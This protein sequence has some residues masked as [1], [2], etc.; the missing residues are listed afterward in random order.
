MLF[1]LE[2]KNVKKIT[3]KTF[4]LEKDIQS[5]VE[6]NME[7]LLGLEFITTEFQVDN[8]N[9]RLDSVAYDKENNAFKIIEYKRG[10]NE[11]LIDQGYTYLNLLFSNKADF[12]LKYNE[13]KNKNLK[14]SDID[15]EQSRVVFISQQF[16]NYQTKANNFKNNPIELIRI[17]KY[18]D[19]IIELDFIEKNSTTE[20]PFNEQFNNKISSVSKQ[21][22]VYTE[23]E[24]INKTS[25]ELK[26]IYY[27][28][29]DVILSWGNIKID[30]K[31]LY[32]AFKGTT[33]IVDIVFYRS[34]LKMSLN[35]KYGELDDLKGLAEDVRNIGKWGNG[36]YRIVIRDDEDFEYILSLIKQSWKRN[37]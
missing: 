11:S 32:V 35:L 24:H 29:K 10:R 28:L 26:E 30:P 21:V 2:N 36:D 34:S 15:W 13:V 6:N 12:V 23:E 5:L 18:E 17:K 7:A 3:E 8:S 4:N 19:N 14:I 33:N 25:V 31:K 20:L 37:K 1:K 22:K 9:L 16:T 27:N